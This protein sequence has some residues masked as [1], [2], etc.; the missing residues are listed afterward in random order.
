LSEKIQVK[1][2][3]NDDDFVSELQPSSRLCFQL[4]FPH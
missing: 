1:V 2:Y 3:A 4:C